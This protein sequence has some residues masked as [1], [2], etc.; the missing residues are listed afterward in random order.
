M[1]RASKL[2]T[3]R[4][5]LIGCSIEITLYSRPTSNK[6]SCPYGKEREACSRGFNLKAR[7]GLKILEKFG[8]KKKGGLFWI[9]WHRN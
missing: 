3:I 1:L 7:Y 6:K 4:R 9:L 5:I 8:F 2:G